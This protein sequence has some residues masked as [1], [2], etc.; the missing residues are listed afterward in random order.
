[1]FRKLYDGSSNELGGNCQTGQLLY[2]GYS[3]HLTNGQ[4][5]Y[6]AYI[7]GG[8]S[9]DDDDGSAAIYQLFDSDDISAINV[10]ENV[11]LRSDDEERTLMSG[12]TLI[13]GMFN[14]NNSR[15]ASQAVG[16]MVF[17]M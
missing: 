12:Q 5:L 2:D 3:Q 11:Y 14:V 17:R 10:T 1:M 15:N 8:G 7:A 16:Y 9:G 13:R 6:D 4:Y